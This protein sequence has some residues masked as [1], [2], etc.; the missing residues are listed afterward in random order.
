MISAMEHLSSCS[1][2]WLHEP[3]TSAVA[4]HSARGPIELKVQCSVVAILQ[5]LE[6]YL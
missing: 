1:L 3:A 4:P 5:F 2:G 6:F